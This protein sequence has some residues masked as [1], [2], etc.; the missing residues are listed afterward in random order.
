MSNTTLHTGAFSS[1]NKHIT[2]KP[3]HTAPLLGCPA[4]SDITQHR[5]H[6]SSP[7]FTQ[8]ADI[9]TFNDQLNDMS[10]LLSLGSGFYKVT[11]PTPSL[12]FT[13]V[14]DIGTFIDQLN[15]ASELLSLGSGFY[16]VNASIDMGGPSAS[17][18]SQMPA[19]QPL[20][21][22]RVSGTHRG[23]SS[24][25]P[26]HSQRVSGTHTEASLLPSPCNLKG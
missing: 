8:V 7:G 13:Q 24:F 3:F 17:L 20:H 14:A 2:S 25:Q 9:G 1:S 16:K 15:D 6:V 11:H 10:E 19:S 4:K 22:Q 23:I 18:V 21:S 12:V 26:L 5:Q